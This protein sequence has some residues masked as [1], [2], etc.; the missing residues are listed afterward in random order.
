[1]TVY[2]QCCENFL[3]NASNGSPVLGARIVPHLPEVVPITLD[4]LANDD[5][6]QFSVFSLTR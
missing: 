1:M 6:I 2:C 5:G 3:K 4:R